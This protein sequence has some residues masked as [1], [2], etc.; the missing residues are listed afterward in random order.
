MKGKLHTHAEKTR[1]FLYGISLRKVK[2][3]K[4]KHYN[5]SITNEEMMQVTWETSQV[6]GMKL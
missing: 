1:T 6:K 2:R 3:K 4:D 5:K